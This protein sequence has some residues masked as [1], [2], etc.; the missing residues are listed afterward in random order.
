MLKKIR[1][2]HGETLTEMASKLFIGENTLRS[3][4]NKKHINNNIIELLLEKY[5]LT[6]SEVKKLKKMHDDNNNIITV[7]LRKLSPKRR[8]HILD[9]LKMKGG[10]Y[11]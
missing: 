10:Y 3:Y 8:Q 7:D 5:V 2:R 6:E 9:I 1:K 11:D 4:E